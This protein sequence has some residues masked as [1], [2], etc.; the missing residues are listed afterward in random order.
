MA[1]EINEAE[2]Q[3]YFEGKDKDT[4]PHC[5]KTDKTF[6]IIKI[7]KN[8]LTVTTGTSLNI[9]YN[10]DHLSIVINN[11]RE[12]NNAKD[13]RK[14][15]EEVVDADV[16][17]RRHHL[18]A[19]AREY[20]DRKKKGVKNTSSTQPEPS[21]DQEEPDYEYPEGTEVE[22]THRGRERDGKV[23]KKAKKLFKK[24]NGR[25]Y[26][27]VCGFYFEEIYGERAKDFI[28]AHHNIPVSEMDTSGTKI[29]DIAMLCSNCHRIIHRTKPWLSVEE[30]KALIEKHSKS[31]R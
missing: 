15:V 23:I 20:L 19:I 27:E 4:I 22:K 7:G 30:L 2:I 10:Y 8:S 31:K 28:E 18:Y 13:I 16:G 11:F 12:Y 29:K 17:C 14:F 26:C 25:L 5:I 21:D 24:N 1:I 3:K 9:R 6:K